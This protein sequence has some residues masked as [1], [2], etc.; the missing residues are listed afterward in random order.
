MSY[1]FTQIDIDNLQSNNVKLYVNGEIVTLNLTI[2][3]GDLLLAECDTGYKFF[4]TYS[5]Q[6]IYSIN[7]SGR[8]SSGST[9]YLT[10]DMDNSLVSG[11]CI[12][13]TNPYAEFTDFNVETEVNLVEANYVVTG[14]DLNLVSNSN[15]E[16]FINGVLAEIGIEIFEGDSIEFRCLENYEFILNDTNSLITSSVYLLGRSDS[17]SN[18]YLNFELSNG[19]TF[20]NSIMDNNKYD[21]LEILTVQ[22]TNVLGNN[23]VY[24]INNEILTQINNVRF[25]SGGDSV[26]DYGEFILSVLQLPFEIDNSQ[27]LEKEE[28]LLADLQTGIEANKLNTDLIIVDLGKIQIQ[29]SELNLLDYKNVEA[30]IHLPRAESIVLDVNYVIDYEISIKYYID[31]YTGIATINIESSKIGGVI[32]TKQVDIGVEMPYKSVTNSAK[33]SNSNIDVGGD[34][35]V[36]VPFI[37]LLKPQFNNVY[38]NFS[39]PILVDDIIANEIGFIKVEE[40]ELEI[41]GSYSE[42]EDILNVL[43]NGVI[44]K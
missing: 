10:F 1:T 35:G 3:D 2:N 34:N 32:V 14:D 13:Q 5:W 9:S 40:I 8:S 30:I 41:S 37:E 22:K 23:N 39:A 20:A 43:R 19:N 26:F 16:M 38:G 29:S 28:I 12:Y 27:I 36:L 6:G 42:K 21:S 17:G 24:I 15:C 31:C 4:E 7:F 11:T 44:I 18:L 25:V 33:I